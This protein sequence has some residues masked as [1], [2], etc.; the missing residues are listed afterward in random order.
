MTTNIDHLAKHVRSLIIEIDVLAYIFNELTEKYLVGHAEDEKLG[1][2]IRKFSNSIDAI[3]KTRD[4]VINIL[5]AD[6]IPDAYFRRS[7]KKLATLDTSK[8]GNTAFFTYVT[9][10][11]K[12]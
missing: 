1:H 7:L 5:V 4:D 10:N 6:N 9:R 2:P 8:D 11:I 12:D 3:N